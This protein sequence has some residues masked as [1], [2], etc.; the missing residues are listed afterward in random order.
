MFSSLYLIIC[1][2]KV[3]LH[4]CSICSALSVSVFL[5]LS[6]CFIY[7]YLSIYL[8][9]FLY[10]Y[11]YTY[12]LIYTYIYIHIYIYYIYIYIYIYIISL[13]TY[14]FLYFYISTFPKVKYASGICYEKL[15]SYEKLLILKRRTQKNKSYVHKWTCSKRFLG[16]ERQAKKFFPKKLTVRNLAGCCRPPYE[17]RGL[18]FPD[19]L[20]INVSLTP[21]NHISRV[22]SIK[23]YNLVM[24]SHL[25]CLWIYWL[26][27]FTL[28]T[29]ICES[30]V[31]V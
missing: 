27:N 5:F 26:Q 7:V 19:N 13:S 12:I 17:I 23:S 9:I 14:I 21:R 25:N 8:S 4:F 1:Y 30:F 31:K 16:S 20:K 3:K 18:K 10:I 15:W 6:L 22:L 28:F 24:D 11:T 2:V 29:V